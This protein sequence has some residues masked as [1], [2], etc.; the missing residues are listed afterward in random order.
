MYMCFY[1]CVFLFVYACMYVCIL[2][3][4]HTGSEVLPGGHLPSDSPTKAFTRAAGGHE[5]DEGRPP[6]GDRTWRGKT[7]GDGGS[8]S[9]TSFLEVLALQPR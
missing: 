1:T 7:R 2:Y 3:S 6:G 9:E 5:G 4:R 8:Y